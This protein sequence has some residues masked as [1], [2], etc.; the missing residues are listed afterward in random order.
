MAEEKGF[1]FEV[2][3]KKYPNIELPTWMLA[4][5]KIRL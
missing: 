4:E 2:S 3:G 5:K 1:Y